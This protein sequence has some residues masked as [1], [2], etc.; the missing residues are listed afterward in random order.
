MINSSGKKDF[1]DDEL[2]NMIK[3][4]HEN[5]IEVSSVFWNP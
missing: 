2:S 5:I 4:F 1:I 3:A